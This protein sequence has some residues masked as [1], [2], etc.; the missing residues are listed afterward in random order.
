MCIFK[1][2]CTTIVNKYL[3]EIAKVTNIEKPL[4]THIAKHTSPPRMAIDK[5][6]NPMVTMELLGHSSL[7]IHQGY[8]NDIRKDDVLDQAVDDIFET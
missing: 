2:S 7:S 6:K 3:K 1:E 5:I 8:L 4:T